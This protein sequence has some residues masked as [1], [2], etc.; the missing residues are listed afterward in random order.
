MSPGGPYQ[1]TYDPPAGT[2]TFTVRYQDYWNWYPP[3]YA[4]TSLRR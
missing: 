3:G 4:T 2:T 1:L